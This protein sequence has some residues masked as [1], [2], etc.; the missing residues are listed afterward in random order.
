MDEI[1]SSSINPSQLNFTEAFSD[2]SVLFNYTL[3]QDN[4]EAEEFLCEHDCEK[5]VS[6]SVRS[7]YQNVRDRR[8][9]IVKSMLKAQ[10]GGGFDEWDPPSHIDLEGN[11]LD[12]MMELT[13]ELDSM[14]PMKLKKRLKTEERRI[15][16]GWE[17]LFES[18]DKLIDTV[19]QCDRD[20]MVLGN[21][22]TTVDNESDCEILCEAANW[23]DSG[24]SGTMVSGDYDDMISNRNSISANLNSIAHAGDLDILSVDEFLSYSP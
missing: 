12:Y 8:K 21:I 2:T 6:S 19:W 11:E 15:V 3:Q 1:M 5:V 14:N 7:E 17:E 10:A 22:R 13:Q 20:P 9:S 4:G 23:S 24:G 18:P 16:R